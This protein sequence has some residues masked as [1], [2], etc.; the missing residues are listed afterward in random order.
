MR[1]AGRRRRIA[2]EL[3]TALFFVLLAVVMTWPLAANLRSAVTDPGDPFI[4]VWILDWDWWATLHAPLRLFDANIF[5]PARDTLAFSEHLYGLAMLLFPLRAVGMAPLTAFNV[6]MLLGFAFSGYAACRLGRSV[7]GSTAGGIAAG[8]FFAFMPFRFTHLPHLQHVMSGW[9]PMLLLALLYYTR[10]PS[11]KRALLFGLT[12]LMNGLTN[13]HWLL[14]GSLAIIAAALILGTTRTRDG[15]RRYWLPLLVTTG[16]ASL[17][18]L[19]FVLPYLEASRLYGMT[20]SWEETIGYSATW[21]DWLISSP[22]NHLYAFTTNPAVDP[23]RWLFPGLLGPLFAIAACLLARRHH[24]VDSADA[25]TQR[26]PGERLVLRAL[27]LAAFVFAIATL[28]GYAALHA[29]SSTLFGAPLTLFGS[30]DVAAMLLVVSIITRFGMRYPDALGGEHGDSLR[31]TMARS[32]FSPVMWAAAVWIVIGVLGS[33]GLHA[34]FHQFLFNHVPGFRGLRVPARWAMIADAGLSLFVAAGT[35]ALVKEGTTRRRM[36]LAMLI[37]IALLLELRTAPIRWYLTVP[38][39]PPAYD[40]IRDTNIEGGVVELPLSQHG[41]EYFAMF[42]A[43][44]HHKPILNGVSGFAPPDYTRMATLANE[45]PLNDAFA[46]Q[47]IRMRCELVLVHG[48]VIDDATRDWL[49]RELASGRIVLLRR[50]DHGVFG[51]WLFAIGNGRRHAASWA[52]AEEPDA[53]AHV[54]SENL[55]LFLSGRPTYNNV[56]FGL[57]DEPSVVPMVQAPYR[58]YGFAFSPWGVDHVDLLFD[59]G[60]VRLP[61][62]FRRDYALGRQFPWYPRAKVARFELILRKR[63]SNISRTTD[64]QVEITDWRGQSTRLE[65]RWITFQY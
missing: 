27:D 10:K 20:R 22:M 58:F 26:L 40:W 64:V 43:A 6:G 13:M 38:D 54:P 15:Q 9:L 45:R 28:L 48:D 23:E 47:L 32:R 52:A 50:F 2:E 7:T 65:D 61:T 24:F 42:H 37:P 63:P 62:N 41:T 11:P 3:A 49:R 4:N 51:D 36:A 17:L 5:F 30:P 1:L 39:P 33:L 29:E 31:S 34:F 16:A 21:S 19:P 46:A 8:I 60:Q 59:N 12:F 14:F 35:A 18:L 57:L 25:S 55:E 56:A 53:A 44:A